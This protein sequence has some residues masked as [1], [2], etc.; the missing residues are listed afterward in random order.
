MLANALIIAGST[1]FVLL[2]AAHMAFTFFT[3]KFDARD[4]EVTAAMKQSSPVLTRDTTMWKAWIGFNASHSLG[5]IFFGLF[6]I[7]LAT[8]HP[9][10]LR[11]SVAF[12]VLA[13]FTCF[14]YLFLAIRYWFRIPLTGI[15]IAT[16]CFCGATIALRTEKNTTRSAYEVPA[17]Y[18]D[19][20]TE[21]PDPRASEEQLSTQRRAHTPEEMDRYI[22]RMGNSYSNAQKYLS[23]ADV[24]ALVALLDDPRQSEYWWDVETLLGFID[25][26]QVSVDALI[27]FIYREENWSTLSRRGKPMPAKAD[28]ISILGFIG[29]DRAT[30]TLRLLLTEEGTHQLINNWSD[31]SIK[32]SG[33]SRILIRDKAAQGLV[34]TQEDANIQLVEELYESLLPQVRSIERRPGPSSVYEKFKT[35]EEG[36]QFTL[37]LGMVSALATRDFI[38]NEG[39]EV[40]KS[41]LHD[42]HMYDR[43][44]LRY[45]G[46]YR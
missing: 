16:L 6:Y 3:N 22:D 40:W 35:D 23:Q 11:E 19:S 30:D 26:E 41:I 18:A 31:A 34:Y 15:I 17:G 21:W 4:S 46:N 43:A 38:E 12:M 24:P 45:F 42:V 25:K 5:A 8:L 27:D 32:G 2:G 7:L 39:I 44:I 13:L 28:A 36:D 29:G 9:E 20:V 14:F 10:V 37:F 33:V 1:I